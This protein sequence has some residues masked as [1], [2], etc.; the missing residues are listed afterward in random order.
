MDE[1]QDMAAALTGVSHTDSERVTVNG[2]ADEWYCRLSGAELGPMSFD[3]LVKCA[4]RGQMLTDDEVRFGA[5]GK[6]R[7]VGSVGRLMAELPFQ[8]GEK[9]VTPS[10][11][12]SK[13]PAIDQP[14]VVNHQSAPSAAP[15]PSP[16]PAAMYS[17]RDL[18]IAYQVAYEQAKAQ[19]AQALIAQGEAAFQ[20]VE[21]QAKAELTRSTAQN[22][23]RDWWGWMNGVEFGPVD[24]LHVFTLAKFGQLKSSDF[25]RNGQFGQ[26]VAAA[27]V[28]GLFNAAAMVARA[29]EVL[30]IAKSQA[31]AAMT[32]AGPPPKMPTS[33]TSTS[34]V[35]V[36]PT[37]ISPVIPDVASSRVSSSAT[38]PPPQSEPQERFTP[39][40]STSSV[41][42]EPQNRKPPSERRH[43][44]VASTAAAASR[45]ASA[46]DV[47]AVPSDDEVLRG[48]ADCLAQQKTASFARIGM[49]VKRGVITV[50]G[51]VASETERLTLLIM[52]QRI[53]GVV[54]VNDG[55][56]ISSPVAQRPVSRQIPTR[57]SSGGSST[58]LPD[59]THW[60]DWPP[61]IRM[62]AAACSVLIV[63]LLGYWYATLGPSRPVAVHPVKGRAVFEGQ[64]MS[65]ANVILHPSSSSKVPAELRP[66]G[67][68]AADGTFVLST[69][70]PNDGAPSGDFV[71]T[72]VWSKPIV[73]DGETQF[74]PN[75]A[76]ATYSKPESSPLKITI[77]P[78]TRE[79]QPLE[80]KNLPK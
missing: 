54:Q 21:E 48:V 15:P 79:L 41:V 5:Q 47:E 35:A 11:P 53:P 22:R 7:Q 23:D 59:L 44:V 18:E 31:Q 61:H 36:K 4:Q 28:P 14:L 2:G 68:V 45:Q 56:S 74:G 64:P 39:T 65:G 42:T 76:P 29:A 67:S 46:S 26:P 17:E 62:V 77:E 57:T 78:G 33:G 12:K 8:P 66:R 27:N 20:A 52:L 69:F 34:A 75:L 40:A 9:K 19:I 6:W 30:N 70:D 63:G 3:G 16:A 43:A 58:S 80:L 51:D 38:V 24:F 50:R 32:L 13:A 60:T 49:D 73:V 1:R 10:A 25:V 55:L 37:A 71:V 72:V